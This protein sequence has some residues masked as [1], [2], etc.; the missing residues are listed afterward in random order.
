MSFVT[1]VTAAGTDGNQKKKKEE[2]PVFEQ[3]ENMENPLRCPVKLY[4][5]YL[6]KWSVILLLNL[7]T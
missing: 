7:L 6:S 4:E 2:M 5:F 1:M 3:A